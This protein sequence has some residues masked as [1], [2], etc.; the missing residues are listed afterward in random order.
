MTLPIGGN[1]SQISKVQP[2][3]WSLDESRCGGGNFVCRDTI[4][5]LMD[6][7]RIAALLQPF[8]A[9][10]RR[11]PERLSSGESAVLT[12]PQLQQ[13]STYL[14]LLLR[15]NSRINLTA[16]REPD[17]IVTRHFG[18]SLFTAQHLFPSVLP[19]RAQP[20]PAVQPGRASAR[21]RLFDFGSGAGFPGL[22]IKIWAPHVDLTLIESNQKKATFLREVVRLLSLDS[23]AVFSGRAQ[24]FSARADVVT[25]RAVERFENSVP[26]ATAL[27]EP[28]GKLA[29]L[30]GQAQVTHA[31]EL[32]S[33]FQ[34]QEPIPIPLSANRVLLIG[35]NNPVDESS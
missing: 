20:L 17:E 33:T 6:L 2:D 27:V 9:S 14:D 10:P 7:Q 32:A 19:T 11:L 16:I 12:E 21:P 15:W 23:A 35:L 31:R 4:C 28:C 25:L 13:I 3:R 34:W 26:I 22:P 1:T 18:E 30:I 29:L 24:N 5:N 8:L